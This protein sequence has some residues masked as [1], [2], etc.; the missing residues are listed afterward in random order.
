MEDREHGGNLREAGERLGIPERGI[1]DFSVNLNPF[2][3]IPKVKRIVKAS[4]G[5]AAFYPDPEYK[6]LRQALSVYY[7]APEDNL[8]CGNGS[9]QLIYLLPQSLELKSALIVEPNFSE[10]ERSLVAA[11]CAITH[12]AGIEKN[13]FKVSIKEL[14]DNVRGHDIV[15]LSNP[16]N[17]V[18]YVYHR[19]ELMNLIEY[20]A[21]NGCSVF[22]DE[23][24]IDFKK[25][26]AAFSLSGLA[27]QFENLIVLRSLT[28]I[29]AVPGLRI[30][31]LIAHRNRVKRI[32]ACLPPWSVNSTAAAV[33]ESVE[34][35]LGHIHT[36]QDFIR[37]ERAYLKKELSKIHGIAVQASEANYLLGKITTGEKVGRLEAALGQRRV[38]I[39]N[40]ANYR[41]LSEAHFRVAVK[42]RSENKKLIRLLRAFFA[43]ENR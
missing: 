8:L 33:G 29:V 37:K 38:F 15:Y 12:L 11:G 26:A 7:R 21:D 28:K 43:K 25:D 9:T 20:C 3:L 14:T 23:A 4:V 41:G 40:C 30:G 16:N 42:R 10:Y 36:T 27:D 1:L 34:E 31:T 6:K 19:Q 5:R 17:P 32:K 22:I 24:F 35:F 2:G 13:N 18:G 39:R